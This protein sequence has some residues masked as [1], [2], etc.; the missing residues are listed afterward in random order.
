VSTK[1]YD[2][3]G[4]APTASEDDIKRAFRAA[5]LKHHPDRGGD[6]ERFK[7]ANRANEVL[8]DASR[9][10]RYDRLGEAGLDPSSPS[11]DGAD[12]PTAQFFQQHHA[13]AFAHM[14]GGVFG[15]GAQQARAS[16]GAASSNLTTDIKV[17]LE[18]VYVGATKTQAL[19]RTQLCTPCKGTG[20]KSGKRTTCS[21]CAGRGVQLLV[22]QIGP[23]MIQQQQVPCDACK[24]SGCTGVSVDDTCGTCR[25]AQVVEKAFTCRI[26]IEAGMY[27]DSQNGASMVMSGQGGRAANSTTAGDLVVNITLAPHDTFRTSAEAPCALLLDKQLSLAEALTGFAFEVRQLDG[28]MLSV[29]SPAPMTRCIKPG[30]VH[31][32]RGEGL[33]F[34]GNPLRRGDLLVTFDVTFPRPVDLTLPI[35]QALRVLLAMPQHASHA[36]AAIAHEVCALEDVPDKQAEL[37]RAQQAYREHR[38]R[39][40]HHTGESQGRAQDPYGGNSN[41]ASSSSTRAQHGCAQQ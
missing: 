12:D 1:L 7:D 34:P 22:R 31:V 14:F 18:E 41:H 35:Q 20:S 9:R 5:A 27:I 26:Q 11:A 25:G 40:A 29:R 13:A 3:L 32:V 38:V 8:S 4:I 37:N 21:V 28:R 10:A 2:V 39:H 15:G 16:A 33:P 36:S 24:G 17:T 19:R 30:M 23:S 6:A